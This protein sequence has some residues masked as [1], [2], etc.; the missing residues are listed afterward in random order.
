M[1]AFL[2]FNEEAIMNQKMKKFVVRHFVITRIFFGGTLIKNPTFSIVKVYIQKE[3][4]LN[5]KKPRRNTK[6]L[7][8]R[9]I[10]DDFGNFNTY[11]LGDWI[12]VC[13]VDRNTFEIKKAVETRFLPK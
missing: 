5:S 11:C 6:H 7:I 1:E 3:L 12:S 2:N 8:R 9:H 4:A 13:K 10:L